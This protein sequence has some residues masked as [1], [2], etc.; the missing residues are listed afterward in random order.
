MYRTGNRYIGFNYRVVNNYLFPFYPLVPSLEE[1]ISLGLKTKSLFS[2]NRMLMKSLEEWPCGLVVGRSLPRGITSGTCS[3]TETHG[4]FSFFHFSFCF[5][6]FPFKTG[7]VSLGYSQTHSNSC[8]AS[9]LITGVNQR[10]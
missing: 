7:R 9:A 4:F 10:A 1:N 2:K 6:W 8:L 5:H 3:L